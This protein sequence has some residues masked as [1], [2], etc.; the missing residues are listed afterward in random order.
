M[1]EKIIALI[2][3]IDNDQLLEFLYEFIKA[4]IKKWNPH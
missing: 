4:S 3:E 1:K 2:N